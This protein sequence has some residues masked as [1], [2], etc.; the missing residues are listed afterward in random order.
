MVERKENRAVTPPVPPAPAPGSRDTMRDPPS[1]ES[2]GDEPTDASPK[3]FDPWKFGAVTIPPGLR[4]EIVLTELPV[5]SPDRLYAPPAASSD[6]S[7]PLPSAPTAD[8]SRSDQTVRLPSRKKA[9]RAYLTLAGAVALLLASAVIVWRA[10]ER[11]GDVPLERS[12]T[13]P[14]PPPRHVRPESF[15]RGSESRAP[16]TIGAPAPV[17]ITRALASVPSPATRPSTDP[18][19][20]SHPPQ[21]RAPSASATV[22]PEALPRAAPS[23]SESAK[24]DFETPFMPD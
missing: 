9:T 23:V 2:R 12:A 11:R 8:T 10:S 15:A 6:E 17:P 20:C 21:T 13:A 7:T 24:P 16:S 4:R 18:P 19:R 5:E 3:Q 14:E 22:R 1:V